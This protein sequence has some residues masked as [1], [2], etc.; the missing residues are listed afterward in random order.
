[1]LMRSLRCLCM[2][3]NMPVRILEQIYG[4][5]NNSF[6]TMPVYLIF[7]PR[8]LSFNLPLFLGVYATNAFL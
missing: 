5:F 3:A 8:Y 6:R 4:I 2:C 1:M 7:W